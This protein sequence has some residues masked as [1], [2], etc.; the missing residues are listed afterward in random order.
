MR[1]ILKS[2]VISEKSTA[3][4]EF[5]KFTFFVDIS[6]NKVEI[7]HYFKKEFDVDVLSVNILNFKPKTKRKGKKIYKTSARKKAFVTI[8]KS[9]NLDKIKS[10]F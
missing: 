5:G 8:D 6:A 10:L 1:N 9:N 2:A 7:K 3:D 4:L